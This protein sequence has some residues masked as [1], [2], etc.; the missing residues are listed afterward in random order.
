M[1][2]KRSM[3]NQKTMTK[4]FP[5]HLTLLCHKKVETGKVLHSTVVT[6][7]VAMTTKEEKVAIPLI[8]QVLIIDHSKFF[9]KL[10]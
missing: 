4:Y 8:D 2:L 3:S 7:F 5:K 6:F 10:N 9:A 1:Q